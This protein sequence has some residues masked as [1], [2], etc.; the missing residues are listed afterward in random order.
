MSYYWFK[1]EELFKKQ[2]KNII[3]KEVNKKPVSII[4]KIK[5]L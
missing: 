5:K 3:I 4:G 1:R 2:M